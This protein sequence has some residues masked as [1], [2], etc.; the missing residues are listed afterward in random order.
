MSFADLLL[1]VNNKPL[2]AAKHKGTL[3]V[4]S[5]GGANIMHYLLLGWARVT[6]SRSS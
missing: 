1:M 4:L 2:S 5:R 3:Q 6:L